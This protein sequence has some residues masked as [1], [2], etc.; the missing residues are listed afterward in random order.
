MISNY[1]KQSRKSLSSFIQQNVNGEIFNGIL[2]EVERSSGEDTV[3]LE[4]MELCIWTA[5]TQ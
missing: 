5:I 1:F 3:V 2:E 4:Q